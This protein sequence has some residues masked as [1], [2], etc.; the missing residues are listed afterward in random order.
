[1]KRRLTFRNTCA[2]LG[3]SEEDIYVDSIGEEKEENEQV[4]VEDDSLELQADEE[5][6][7]AFDNE[8]DVEVFVEGESD[9]SDDE[10]EPADR[11]SDDE[12]D[13]DWVL[14][15]NGISYT[16][17]PIPARRLQTNII[18]EAPR[19]MA[20]PRVRRTVFNVWSVKKFFEL[21]FFTQIESHEKYEEISTKHAIQQPCSRWMS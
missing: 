2:Q 9:S 21:F 19:A 3:I 17:Q 18:T 6:N 8:G 5:E 1:M 20:Q 14:S 15:P 12:Q 10:E 4:K 7:T 16:S 13:N 11:E